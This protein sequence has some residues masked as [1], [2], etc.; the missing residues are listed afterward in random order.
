MNTI[1]PLASLFLAATLALAAPLS[2]GLYGA[3]YSTQTQTTKKNMQA[4]PATLYYSQN[5]THC[6]KVMDYLKKTRKTVAL[7][8]VSNPMY[9]KELQSYGQKGVPALIVGSEVYLGADQIINYLKQHPEIL[10]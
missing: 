6:H 7:K 1:I 2:T 3:D 5:C 4:S 8:D 10:R 9:R